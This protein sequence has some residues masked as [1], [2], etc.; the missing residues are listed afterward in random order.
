VLPAQVGVRPTRS[1]YRDI[2]HGSGWTF[3]A[4][5]VGGDGGP[6]QLSPNSGMSYGVRF[7]ARF[8]GLLQ[9]FVGLEYMGLE[10]MVLHPDDSVVNRFS[11]PIDA[12]VWIPAIGLQVNLTGPKTW[13]H[14]APFAA[15]TF[16]A[17]IGETAPEDTTKFDFGTKLLLAP[18]GG[19]RIFI[20]QR[21]HMRV[22]A[23]WYMWKMKYPDNWLT[24]P[25]EQPS[26]PGEPSTAP[27][28]E[29]EDLEDWVTTPSLRLGL[30]I[31][32]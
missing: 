25:S 22:E 29:I 5:Q 30:G 28:K 1:P 17:A 13:R 4:G 23:I 9:G 12:P 2:L 26:E 20:G 24:E 31:A 32:F 7:D 14:I 16:G 11:G 27:I 8:S 10:R 18:S 15:F 19:A 21:I 3:M 6:M